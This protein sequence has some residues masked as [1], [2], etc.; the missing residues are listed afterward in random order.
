[1]LSKE[2]IN[3]KVGE[4][5]MTLDKNLVNEVN[6]YKQLGF[7]SQKLSL[8]DVRDSLRVD[9]DTLYPLLYY[10]SHLLKSNIVFEQTKDTEKDKA[11][12]T[13][14]L[15]YD[16]EVDSYIY[17]T[18]L[19]KKAEEGGNGKEEPQFAEEKE[20]GFKEVRDSTY[21]NKIAN[22]D[23]QKLKKM[24]VKDLKTLALELKI[25]L[26]KTVETV[27]PD[28]GI[29]TTKKAALLKEELVEKISTLIKSSI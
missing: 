13:H 3:K 2:D 7:K 25:D 8:D 26:V 23:V 1:L 12:K 28:T 17:M 10:A 4:F 6:A 18:D 9:R 20:S 16:P 15:E 22:I 27:N 24:S 29:K 14:V 19:L 21:N 11:P 5:K